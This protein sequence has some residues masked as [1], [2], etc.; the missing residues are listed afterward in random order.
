MCTWVPRARLYA[1]VV[2]GSHLQLS[3][4]VIVTAG[5]KW[6]QA[7]NVLFMNWS[8]DDNHEINSEWPR[9]IFV[10]LYL[11]IRTFFEQIGHKMFWLL[12]GYTIAKA[13]TSTRNSTWF[14][15][16]F[17]LVRVWGLGTRLRTV[18][19]KS[20]NQILVVNAST[21]KMYVTTPWVW[22]KGLS[23][24]SLFIVEDETFGEL[25][26]SV[27]LHTQFRAFNQNISATVLRALEV[28]NF[29]DMVGRHV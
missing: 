20:S 10:H 5:F 1:A 4:Q 16:P 28:A 27:L 12:L 13:C 26:P 24:C 15:R 23:G 21:G 11:D 3:V 18:H 7:I 2:R 19:C 6:N 22:S 8:R 9:L 29:V 14:T 25:I 17:L